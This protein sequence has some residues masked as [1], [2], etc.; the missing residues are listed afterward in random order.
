MSLYEHHM[1]KEI[2]EQPGILAALAKRSRHLLEERGAPLWSGEVAGCERILFLACGT[3]YHASLAGKWMIET[4]AGIPCQVE[5]AHEYRMAAQLPLEN[6]LAIGLS[7]SGETRD[8]LEAMR[9]AKEAGARTLAICNVANSTA[10]RL[11]HAAFL[12]EAGP[13]KAIAS[14]KVFSAQY[15]A[16]FLLA[17][18]LGLLRGRLPAEWVQKQ[19]QQLAALPDKMRQVLENDGFV[20]EAALV[21]R[22]ATQLLMIGKGPAFPIALEGA[23]KLKE[24]AYLHA[25]GFAGGEFRHGPMALIEPSVPTLMLMPALPSEGFELMKGTLGEIRK[26]GGP[27]WALTQKPLE[28]EEGVR[29]HTLPEADIFLSPLLLVAPLQLLAYRLACSRGLNVDTPRALC[30]AVTSDPTSTP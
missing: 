15:V 27:I 30:K 20:K 2:M 5:Y 25:E 28:E 7:Q 12:L 17:L 16:T 3:S 24:T 26:S 22:E 23:L 8:S 9:K 10:I 21:L 1:L 19:L 4:L 6:C 13:E 11:A 18:H 29:A 14:T